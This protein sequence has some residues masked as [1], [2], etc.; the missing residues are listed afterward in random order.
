M[1]HFPLPMWQVG[2]SML[3]RRWNE[4]YPS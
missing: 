2:A 4:G 3:H 1:I